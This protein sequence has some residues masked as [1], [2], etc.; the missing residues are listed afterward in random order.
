VESSPTTP[1]AAELDDAAPEAVAP[2]DGATEAVTPSPT[3][4]GTAALPARARPGPRPPGGSRRWAPMSPPP[5]TGG[6]RGPG[7][8]DGQRLVL[9]P[10][11][12]TGG[13][14]APRVDAWASLPAAPEDRTAGWSATWTGEE[15]LYWGG[16]DSRGRPTADGLALDPDGFRWRRLP[17]APIAARSHHSAVWGG[18]R[19]WVFGGRDARGQPLAD[20]AAYDPATGTWEWLPSAP[21]GGRTD[22]TLAWVP[23]PVASRDCDGGVEPGTCRPV[24]PGADAERRTGSLLV[25]GGL[26]GAED[27]RDGAGLMDGARYRLGDGWVRIAPAP[28]PLRGRAAT[29]WTGAAA[30]PGAPPCDQ[31]IPCHLLLAWGRPAVTLSERDGYAYDVRR[32]RWERLPLLL[33]QTRS[34]AAAAW[35]GEAIIVFGGR[36]QFDRTW[37][38]DGYFFAPGTYRWRQIPRLLLDVGP[39]PVVA[40][41]GEELLVWG[42]G[43][44]ARLPLDPAELAGR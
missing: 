3:D 21:L 27:A 7:I 24:S 20:G 39:R 11:S 26:D 25:W 9:W 33:G 29:A 19:L 1:D 12:G 17:A 15:V 30:W 43:V 4:D 16:L 44:G 22:A 13:V 8:W 18:G 36:D 41:T 23:D 37:R 6:M 10:G 42:A 32:D 34:D 14:Y 40:W 28:V 35:S 31:P 5:F 38:A 2:D